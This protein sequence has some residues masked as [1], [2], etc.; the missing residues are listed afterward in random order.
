[1]IRMPETVKLCKWNGK[2]IKY[3]LIIN[4]I[5]ELKKQL[6]NVIKCFKIRTKCVGIKNK[7][8]SIN[9]LYKKTFLCIFHVIK[10]AK[11]L[12]KDISGNNR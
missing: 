8:L 6:D 9:S 4:K 3:I 2:T 5:S 12:T 10:V 1:M 7:N 11:L